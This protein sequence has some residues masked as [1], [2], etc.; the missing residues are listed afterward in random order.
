MD[1][2][3]SDD[4]P[5]RKPYASSPVRERPSP[6]SSGSGSGRRTP[7]NSAP[8]LESKCRPSSDAQSADKGGSLSNW[9]GGIT[10]WD[11]V[12]SAR[13]EKLQDIFSRLEV[14]TVPKVQGTVMSST[15]YKSRQKDLQSK[16]LNSCPPEFSARFL[17]EK[18]RSDF[19]TII[20]DWIRALVSC[21]FLW[22]GFPLL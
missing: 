6:L 7:K 3:R 8:T 12:N 10:C 11:D 17:L 4:G 16:L 18:F 5:S 20:F 22:T 9:N 13:R 19:N 14:L 1:P 2:H 21:Y 15:V